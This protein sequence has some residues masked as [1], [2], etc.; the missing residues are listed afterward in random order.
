MLNSSI[1]RNHFHHGLLARPSGELYRGN[2][3]EEH[4]RGVFKI[5]EHEIY[6]GNRSIEY[7][8]HLF[9]DEKFDLELQALD[10]IAQRCRSRPLGSGRFFSIEAIHEYV[11]L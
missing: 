8:I 2:G 7:F 11:I 1:W 10:E 5:L 4:Q 6:F 9:I 3:I